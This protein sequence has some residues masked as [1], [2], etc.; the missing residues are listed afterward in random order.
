M[1][2]LLEIRQVACCFCLP[3]LSEDLKW[4]E[5]EKQRCGSSSTP[6]WHMSVL[7]TSAVTAP[8]SGKPMKGLQEYKILLFNVVRDEMF[9]VSLNWTWY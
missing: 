5:T 2:H 6:I 1:N 9:L 3:C 8:L 4:P 7:F